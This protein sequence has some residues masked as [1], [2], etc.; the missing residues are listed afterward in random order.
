MVILMGYRGARTPHMAR[1]TCTPSCMRLRASPCYALNA[2]QLNP[3]GDTVRS[4]YGQPIA[5]V[6]GRDRGRLSSPQATPIPDQPAE[7]CHVSEHKDNLEPCR[8]Y[9]SRF[10]EPPS[11]GVST[12]SFSMV[13]MLFS[14]PPFSR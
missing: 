7:S 11:A 3:R 10:L 4:T 12:Q 13:G 2:P 5:L 8:S 6:R 9:G 14:S 1:L